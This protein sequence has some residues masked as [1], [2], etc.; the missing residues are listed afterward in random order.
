MLELRF[1]GRGGQ[2]AVTS[3]ELLALA[4]IAQGKF[5]QA[6]PSFGPERRGAP[7]IAYAR[8][9]E[10]QIRN[11][12]AVTTPNAVLVLDPSLLSIVNTSDGLAGNGF[13]VVNSTKTA[14][15]LKDEY[16]LA[17]KLAVV[18][19]NHIAI[20]EIGRAITNTT[21]LGALVKAT[22]LVERD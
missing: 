3:A 6:F 12:T 5:A 17:G 8:I 10:K 4:A 14:A 21:L 7:V 19:A 18:N 13:Q 20:E 9:D 1:H 11:R 22:G 16:G 15:E 2:G